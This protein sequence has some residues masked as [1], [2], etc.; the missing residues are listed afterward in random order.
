MNKIR[1]VSFATV[2]LAATLV[3]TPLR[4]MAEDI[5]IFTGASG[6]SS[7]NPNV[8]LVVDNTSNWSRASQDWP[9]EATQGA[10]EM[11][12]IKTVVGQLD[13]SVNVGLMVWT[14]AGKGGGEIRFPV[15]PMTATN[16]A[17][18]QAVAQSIYDNITDPKNKGPSN[19]AYEGILFDAWKYFGGYASVTGTNTPTD[20][21]HF[22]PAVYNT[23][24][25]PCGLADPRGYTNS[26]CTVF[27]SPIQS[28]G[29]CA[30]NYVIFIGNNGPSTPNADTAS[31]LTGIGGSATQLARPDVATGTVYTD[32]GFSNTCSTKAAPSTLPYTVAANCA[33][34]TLVADTTQVDTTNTCSTTGQGKWMVQCSF[35]GVAP[36]IPAHSTVATDGRL[37][38]NWSK[39]MFQGDA[40][41]EAGRQGIV[42]Y[43]LDAYNKQFDANT[44]AMLMNMATVASGRYYA[45][46]SIQQI[47][48]ALGEIFADITASNSTFASA[49]LPI[50][51]TNRQVSANAVFIGQFRPDQQA[52]PRWMGNLKKYQL[53]DIGNGIELGDSTTPGKPAV[54]ST[55]GFISACATSFWT[56]DS[57]T[58]WNAVPETPLPRGTCPAASTAF[59]PFSDSPDGPIVEKGSVAEVIRKGNNPPTTNTTPT[60]LVNR[61]I[62]TLNSANSALAAFDTTTAASLTAAQIDWV[63]GQDNK[64]PPERTGSTS[65]Q[66]R[67]SLHGDV[68][69]SRPL[70]IDQGGSIGVTAYYGSGDGM[71]RAINSNGKELWAFVAPEQIPRL[72]R[73]E[74]N[75]PLI[76]Y[77]N[78]PTITPT[79]IP[80]DYF[81]DG[82]SGVYQNTANTS[83]WIYASQRRGGRMIYGFDVSTPSS[84]SFKWRAGCPNLGN[85]TGCVDGTG[86]AAMTGMGQSWSTPAVAF[87]KGFS[88]TVPVVIVGGGYSSCE[89][90]DSST[91]SCG[92]TKGNKIF[93][94][95][96][97]TGAVLQEFTTERAVAADIS[98]VDI[99]YDGM[100][101]YAYAADTGGNLYRIDFI[102]SPTTRAVLANGSWVGHTI[103]YTNG[104]GRKF[105]F[106]PALLPISTKVYVALGSGDRER[107]LETNYPYTT[108]VTNRF[109]VLVDDLTVSSSLAITSGTRGADTAIVNLDSTTTQSNF[110]TTTT[111]GTAGIQP[112]STAKGWFMDLAAGRGEQTVTA[113]VTIGGLVAF[114]TNRPLAAGSQSCSKPQGEARGYLVNLLNAS[115]AIGATGICG[116]SRSAVFAG[117]GG[118]PPSPVISTVDVNGVQQTI[119]IGCAS[120]DPNKPSVPIQAQSF[121][122][123]VNLKRHPIYWFTAGDN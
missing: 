100:V 14:R 37:G 56:T 18:L 55:T 72:A 87:I 73:L 43:T 28:G 81:F 105:L 23:D 36:V 109:Y 57:G 120:K 121:P 51:A 118:L 46:K 65:T 27:A 79:P 63:K 86:A 68:V 59:D 7:G 84:P 119:C 92:T 107:P 58:W 26:S 71:F 33:A 78:L 52:K 90:T 38:D 62:Y 1:K 8:L 112:V 5:D 122:P 49:S 102:S 123:S 61:S 91:P 80:K 41:S 75:D 44:T 20:S 12:A 114:S 108:P 2:V 115:G 110:T 85:D 32:V 39:Y 13:A 96:A 70:V 104:A 48:T 60:W 30:N 69:H 99:D 21:T 22:G 116:G 77:P 93:V 10:A 106:A 66:T 103:A 97:D 83:V 11:Q 9:D 3:L 113:A 94:L 29:G 45:V 16:K 15:L 40:S 53:I 34:G 76:S 88:T 98:L 6:G 25:P 42:T 89:D 4:I 47:K 111:C 24:G 64:V 74:S 54:D 95:R 35:P 31:L 101:D 82:S 67:P 19:A 50:S 17:A 117:P